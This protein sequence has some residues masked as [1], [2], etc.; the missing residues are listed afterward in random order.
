MDRSPFMKKWSHARSS[1]TNVN[2]TND[3]KFLWHETY[4]DPWGTGCKLFVPNI[5]LEDGRMKKSADNSSSKVNRGASG[6]DPTSIAAAPPPGGWPHKAECEKWFSFDPIPFSCDPSEGSPHHNP[7]T[8]ERV[9]GYMSGGGE[10]R[11]SS[12][13][14]SD[15]SDEKILHCSDGTGAFTLPDNGDEYYFMDDRSSTD[16][17]QGVFLAVKTG[18]GWRFFHF[19]EE[20]NTLQEYTEEIHKKAGLDTP[21]GRAS[22]Q[23]IGLI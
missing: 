15:S 13:S 20:A 4:N 2:D 14:A 7:A 17:P 9:T 10:R 23:C 1:I 22:I 21:R 18:I 19:W 11:S 8:W 16:D 12:W 5:F 3:F 6:P